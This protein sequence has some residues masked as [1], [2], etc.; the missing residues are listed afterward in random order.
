MRIKEKR[1]S[2]QEKPNLKIKVKILTDIGGLNTKLEQAYKFSNDG[3]KTKLSMKFKGQEQVF[4]KLDCEK[5]NNVVAKPSGV[6]SKGRS[7]SCQY[8]LLFMF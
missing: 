7:S 1:I 2:N 4:M 3:C 6:S 8:C 5:L